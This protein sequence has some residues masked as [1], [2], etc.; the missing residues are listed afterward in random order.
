MLRRIARKQGGGAIAADV[1]SSE[2][3]R[4]VLCKAYERKDAG[5][6]SGILASVAGGVAS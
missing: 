4:P 6:A 2:G 3:H 1:A 5:D